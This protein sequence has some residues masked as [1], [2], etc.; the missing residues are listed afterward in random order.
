MARRILTAKRAAWAQA[1]KHDGIMRGHP[2]RIPAG[3]A[4]RYAAD[5]EKL[6]ASMTDETRR[7]IEDL[8]SH[9]DVHEFFAKHGHPGAM[10]YAMDISP[11]SQARIL[12][13]KLKARFEQLFGQESKP[14]AQKMN[15]EVNAASKTATHSSLTEL[16]GGLSLK[17]DIVS[18]AMR[19]FMTGTIARNV[20]LIRSIPA[21]YFQQ[22]QDAALRSITDGK[23]LADLV[24]AIQEIEGVTHRRAQNIANDQTRKAYGGL[25][26]GRM[27]AIGV[28]EYEWVHSGG[29]QHPRQ[30]HIDMDGNIYRFDDPPIIEEDGE[31]GI[32]GQAI[33]CG[34][35]MRPVIRFN[36]GEIAA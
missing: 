1:R 25:N 32:P 13:N 4:A 12:T 19:E 35:T 2:L 6:V 23:G 11:S 5:L 20:G 26:K 15:D 8:F 3:V 22:I 24:P 7:S 29:G 30:M 27:Q 28:K 16:S 17:T 36:Q 10:T 14:T 31:R 21:E 34:C 18:G 33:H 9:P